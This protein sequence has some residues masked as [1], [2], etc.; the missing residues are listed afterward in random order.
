MSDEK[1]K[2][3]KIDLA[4]AAAIAAKAGKLVGDALKLSDGVTPQEATALVASATALVD[5]IKE[6]LKD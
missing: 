5:E 3:K 1:P 2:K 6:A 4:E